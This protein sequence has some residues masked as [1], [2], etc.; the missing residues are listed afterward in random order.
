MKKIIVGVKWNNFNVSDNSVSTFFN[1]E[2]YYVLY[3][4]LKNFLQLI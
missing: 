1:F 3:I 4:M 2:Q